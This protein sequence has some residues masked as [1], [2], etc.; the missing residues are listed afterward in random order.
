MLFFSVV[1]RLLYV[2]FRFV[3]VERF[4]LG[5]CLLFLSIFE[6]LLMFRIWKEVGL[7]FFIYF[8][9]RDLFLFLL[10]VWFWSYVYFWKVSGSD[11]I[12]YYYCIFF[13]ILIW[14]KY[15]RGFIEIWKRFFNFGFLMFIY[16]CS[17]KRKVC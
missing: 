14:E 15:L 9:L 13:G 4:V 6:C 10:V 5:G 7:D 1:F 12:F 3:N 16:F 11:M 2:F 8:Y 17:L